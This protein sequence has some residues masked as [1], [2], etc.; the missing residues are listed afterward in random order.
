MDDQP[1]F[2]GSPFDAIRD[3]DGGREF[4]K[5]RELFKLLGYGHQDNVEKVIARAR[6][7]CEFHGH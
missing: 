7:A 5:T 6:C 1:N 3:E 2:V 4:W